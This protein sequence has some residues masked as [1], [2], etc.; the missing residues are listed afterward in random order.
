MIGRT[1]G[2]IFLLGWFI[3]GLVMLLSLYLTGAL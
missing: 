2:N 3:G 1:A